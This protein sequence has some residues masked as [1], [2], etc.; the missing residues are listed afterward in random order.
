MKHPGKSPVF[1]SDAK[2]QLLLFGGK[3]GVGKTTASV[4]TALDIADRY[5]ER[6]LLPVST[7]PAHSLQDS[8]SG[9]TPPPNLNVLELDAQAY[10]LDFKEKN[11]QR[12][13]EIA[14]RGTF[15]DERKGEG[16][17]C[18]IM[19]WMKKNTSA[20]ARPWTGS[21]TRAP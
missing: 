1:L 4:A 7:D 19:P 9:G 2:L 16:A 17:V 12:L 15:L 20:F 10:L 6:S 3:G 11:R 14:S 18:L 5:P 8:L 21:L 13:K